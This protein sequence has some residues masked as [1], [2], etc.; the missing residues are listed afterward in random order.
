MT[1]NNENQ[2]DRNELDTKMQVD[3]EALIWAQ[4]LIK[5]P[6]PLLRDVAR[7]IKVV[8][9]FA[10][11]QVHDDTPLLGLKDVPESAVQE[12]SLWIQFF[13]EHSSGVL[14]EAGRHLEEWVNI[15]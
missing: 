1:S 9:N 2:T 12:V 4:A 15:I 6:N 8:C 5:H 10:D 11:S 7:F 14:Y 3:F 13:K